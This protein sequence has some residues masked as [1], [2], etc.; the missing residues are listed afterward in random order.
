MSANKM[1][2]HKINE[3]IGVKCFITV[4]RVCSVSKTLKAGE[5]CAV[6]YSPLIPRSSAAVV[7]SRKCQ[8]NPSAPH[9]NPRQIPRLLAPILLPLQACNPQQI[10]VLLMPL[11]PHPLRIHSATAEERRGVALMTEE[12]V[13]RGGGGT[14]RRQQH[15]SK[16]QTSWI[17]WE[18]S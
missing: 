16:N 2:W 15:N 13:H 4:K 7:Y 3:E 1:M 11:L 6:N 14:D 18:A 10:P 5:T 8:P 12:K 9:S 17:V